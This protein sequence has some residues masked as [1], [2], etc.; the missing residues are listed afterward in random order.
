MSIKWA[1]KQSER[2]EYIRLCDAYIRTATKHFGEYHPVFSELYELFSAYHLSCSEYEDAI[3]FA[4]SSLVN[5]LRVCGSSHEKTAEC[6]FRLALCYIK[7]SRREEGAAHIRKALAILEANAKTEGILYASMQLK[8][9]L[10]L[11]N[12]GQVE[13]CARQVASA[14][15]VF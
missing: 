13:D 3:T 6:Y 15:A 8:L 2:E 11:L 4:K 9:G 1:L 12:Q 14:Q 10:L 5:I 7:S